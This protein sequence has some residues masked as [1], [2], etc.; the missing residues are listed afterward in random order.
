M[1]RASKIEVCL[2]QAQKL[3]KVKLLWDHRVVDVLAEGY[4]VYYGAR[5][6]KYEV[7]CMIMIQTGLKCNR[8][9]SMWTA[10]LFNPQY[11][12]PLKKNY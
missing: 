9:E 12:L 6:I 1:H 11:I 5:S 3:H 4:D 2:L 7:R 8:M 10:N